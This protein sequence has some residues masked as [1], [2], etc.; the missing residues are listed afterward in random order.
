M[1]MS[2]WCGSAWSQVKNGRM[3]SNNII[4]CLGLN[5]F[6]NVFD[7]NDPELKQ[8][9]DVFIRNVLEPVA[10]KLGW[11]VQTNEDP[12]RSQLRGLILGCLSKANHSKT[13]D[14]A[15]KLFEEYS[16]GKTTLHPDLRPT[17]NIR[18]L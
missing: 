7:H 11:T 12:H 15:L 4:F 14:Q 16:N 8:K 2:V 5:S 9:L 3:P 6:L 18:F 13:I 17:V 1:K 10:D